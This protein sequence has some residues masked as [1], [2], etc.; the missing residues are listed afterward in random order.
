M[1]KVI[2]MVNS[3]HGSFISSI[4]LFIWPISLS[5][6]GILRVTVPLDW[7]PLALFSTPSH[8]EFWPYSPPRCLRCLLTSLV[9]SWFC[10]HRY[11]HGL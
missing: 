7:S 1:D 10:C 4:A 3:S 5:K 11:Y 8:P 6:C 9:N 2:H